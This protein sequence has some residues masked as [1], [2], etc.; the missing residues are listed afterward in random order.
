MK[1]V[2]KFPSISRQQFQ[3]IISGMYIMH[4]ICYALNIAFPTL[5]V[6]L[7]IYLFIYFLAKRFF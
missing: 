3:D 6:Y 7:F 1:T 4:L 2:I 5:S